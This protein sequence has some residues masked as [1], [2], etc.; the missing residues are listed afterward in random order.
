MD[1]IKNIKPTDAGIQKFVASGKTKIIDELEKILSFYRINYISTRDLGEKG[2]QIV[3]WEK[4]Q[5]LAE[6]DSF[7]LSFSNPTINSSN[8][9]SVIFANLDMYSF[10]F[11]PPGNIF[12]I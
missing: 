7:I 4:F 9:S 10:A 3:D 1:A 12:S 8:W 11:C 5:E 2:I 6:E